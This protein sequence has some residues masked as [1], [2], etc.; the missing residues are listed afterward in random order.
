MA[1]LNNRG[2]DVVSPEL[3]IDVSLDP[4]RRIWQA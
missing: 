4:Q 3:E 2:G 1:L